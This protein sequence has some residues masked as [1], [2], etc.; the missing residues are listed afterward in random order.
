MPPGLQGPK[1]VKKLQPGDPGYQPGKPTF[2]VAGPGRE[3]SL[4]RIDR[5]RTVLVNRRAQLTERI[6][7]QIAELDA[8]RAQLVDLGATE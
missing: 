1:Q 6:D 5:M 7:A 4:T 2:R 3:I 8:L